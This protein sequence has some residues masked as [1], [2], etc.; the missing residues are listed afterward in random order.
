MAML[1]LHLYKRMH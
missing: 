1:G